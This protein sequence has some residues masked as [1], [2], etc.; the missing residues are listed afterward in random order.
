MRK[1]ILY[2]QEGKQFLAD[3]LNNLGDFREEVSMDF[4]NFAE[5]GHQWFAECTQIDAEIIEYSRRIARNQEVRILFCVH[6]GSDCYILVHGFLAGS[7]R[8][9]RADLTLA[10]RRMREFI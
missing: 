8:T 4:V 2:N 7:E 1:A 9:K 3:F 5:H 10:R 6:R